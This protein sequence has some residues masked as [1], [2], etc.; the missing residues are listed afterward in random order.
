MGAGKTTLGKKLAK[1][2][3]VQFLDTDKL[4]SKE[5]GQITSLF[6]NLGES[7]F[8][9]IETNVLREA[10]SQQAVIATGGGIVLREA[11]REMLKQSHV[12]FLD[13]SAKHVLPKINVEKRPLLKN[14]PNAWG[15]IYNQRLPLY[16]EVSR[17]TLFTG[18]KPVSVALKELIELANKDSHE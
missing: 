7:G 9:D 4:I 8:R 13:S 17:K 2:L 12:I 3:F 10:L 18:G 5:H 14:N 11:N 16:K 15:E 6:E 1:S